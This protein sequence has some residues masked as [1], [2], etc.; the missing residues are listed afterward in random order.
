MPM[1]RIR[2]CQLTT[3][4]QPAGAERCVY[5]LARRLDPASFE[6]LVVGLRGGRVVDWLRDQGRAVEVLGV[7]GKWDV[8]KLTRLAEI[9]KIWQPDV[10]HT[11]LFHAELAGYFAARL[12]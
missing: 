3:E 4:L 5:E 1:A 9:L 12:A 6:V 10:L 2:V 11:H 8:L 7:R